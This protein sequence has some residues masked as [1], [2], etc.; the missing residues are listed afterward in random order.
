MGARRARADGPRIVIYG[1]LGLTCCAPP[2]R[3]NSRSS[4]HRP[5]GIE[6]LGQ[7]LRELTEAVDTLW[8]ALIIG[9][10]LIYQGGMARAFLRRRADLARYLT[11]VPGWARNVVESMDE[12]LQL[13]FSARRARNRRDGVAP[14]A[15]WPRPA[16]QAPCAAGNVAPARGAT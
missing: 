15:A 12:L 16:R 4:A 13:R 3:R 6:G 5:G 14:A 11:E 2:E 8:Y 7:D 10:A 1:I 9:V